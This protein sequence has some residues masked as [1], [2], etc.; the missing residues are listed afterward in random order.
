MQ[1]SLHIHACFWENSFSSNSSYKNFRQP[2]HFFKYE[3]FH[4]T[5]YVYF[6]IPVKPT[7]KLFAKM[8]TSEVLLLYCVVTVTPNAVSLKKNVINTTTSESQPLNNII[9]TKHVLFVL[10]DKKIFLLLWSIVLAEIMLHSLGKRGK[11][12]GKC[13]RA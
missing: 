8:K 13:Q 7:K 11:Y 5:S 2:T 12:V 1:I 9:V 3:V 6:L 4:S 10:P